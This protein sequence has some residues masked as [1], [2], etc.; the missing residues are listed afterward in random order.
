[1]VLGLTVTI[2]GVALALYSLPP[3]SPIAFLVLAIAAVV[4]YG[5]VQLIRDSRRA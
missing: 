3:V 1:M 4:M 5:G 2:V